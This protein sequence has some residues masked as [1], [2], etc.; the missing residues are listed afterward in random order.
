VRIRGD[1]SIWR[2]VPLQ[3]EFQRHDLVPVGRTL[4]WRRWPSKSFVSLLVD[5]IALAQSVHIL[6]YV[7]FHETMADAILRQEQIKGGASMT[8]CDSGFFRICGPWIP[9]FAGMTREGRMRS[10]PDRVGTK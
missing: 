6:V 1:H 5:A 4:T 3:R 8:A 2:S 7:E 9:P 10:P